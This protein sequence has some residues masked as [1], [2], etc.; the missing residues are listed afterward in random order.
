[1]ASIL[2]HINSFHESTDEFSL[3]CFG[4]GPNGIDLGCSF[5]FEKAFMGPHVPLNYPQNSG[6]LGT[7][8]GNMY[9]EYRENSPVYTGMPPQGMINF[10]GH[11]VLLSGLEI[12]SPGPAKWQFVHS[13]KSTCLTNM[14]KD[15]PCKIHPLQAHV[16][17]SPTHIFQEGKLTTLFRIGDKTIGVTS[18]SYITYKLEFKR[19]AANSA[20]DELLYL[21]CWIDTE[22]GLCG[23]QMKDTA[24]RETMLKLFTNG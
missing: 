16:L 8:N 5:R 12:T 15:I 1:M 17:F 13:F 23:I 10:L 7:G 20:E 19:E 2:M 21:I 6:E 11:L 18:S 14:L 4:S 9:Y 24:E 22:N 3:S